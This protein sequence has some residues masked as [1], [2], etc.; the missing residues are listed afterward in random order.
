MKNCCRE[1]LIF[2][3]WIWRLCLQGWKTEAR[4]ADWL[5][6]RRS[7]LFG[8]RWM[9]WRRKLLRIQPRI[10]PVYFHPL[11]EVIRE[12]GTQ[13][14]F[15]VSQENSGIPMYLLTNVQKFL[16]AAAILYPGTL[17]RSHM[18]DETKFFLFFPAAFMSAF[19]FRKE[20]D[21]PSRCYRKWWRRWMRHRSRSRKFCPRRFIITIG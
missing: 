4:T 15:E 8:L 11:E 2:L 17:R 13:M 21:A 9:N 5:P 1:Y 12:L 14:D 6:M 7:R 20:W 19:L 16:G 10:C 3:T 18:M